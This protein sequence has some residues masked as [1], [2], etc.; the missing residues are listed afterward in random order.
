MKK[1][2]GYLKIV[3]WSEEHQCYVGTCPGLLA[4]GGVY[5]DDEAAVY[6]DLCRYAR[7]WIEIMERD[8]ISLPE[9]TAGKSYS[10][11][12]VL[13]TGEDLHRE[14]SLRALVKGESL[15]AY[16]VELLKNGLNRERK[17]G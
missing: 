14:L 12:F 15:N 17:T 13:R 9:E 4:G 2:D 7:E 3:E 5:G 10:G 6:K 8:G 16:C 11:K 1:S